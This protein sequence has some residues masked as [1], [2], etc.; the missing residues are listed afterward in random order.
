MNNSLKGTR[1]E[2]AALDFVRNKGY[3]NVRKSN[4]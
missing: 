4:H 3:K 1:G 2:A